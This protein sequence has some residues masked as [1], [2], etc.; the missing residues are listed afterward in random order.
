MFRIDGPDVV[1]EKPEKK[2]AAGPA[3]WFDGG[4]PVLNQ[5]AT[6]VTRDW[7]NTTMAEIV[8]VIEGADIAL[9][10]SDDSQLLQAIKKLVTVIVNQVPIVPVGTV[11]AYWGN[12]AP[13]GYLAC[14]GQNFLAGDH[15]ELYALL[16]EARTPDLRGM[17]LRGYKTGVSNPIGVA[18]P[19][20]GRRVYCEFNADNAMRGLVDG[21]NFPLKGCA[22]RGQDTGW[23][24]SS[25]F[26][27]TGGGYI[28]IDSTKTWEAA[29]TAEEFRPANVAI[30]YCIKH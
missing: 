23:D 22:D 24:A 18:Q 4:N 29:H 14:D 27:S 1:P 21:I 17:F 15:P 13:D 8:N 11:I 26:G 30:L 6:M 7:L 19:D 12:V 25:G 10:R 3:G 16:G 28:R 20:A 9:D 2:P 5:R